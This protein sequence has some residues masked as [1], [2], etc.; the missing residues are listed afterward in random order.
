MCDILV[1]IQI[2]SSEIMKLMMEGYITMILHFLI[3]LLHGN[4]VW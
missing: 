1:C 2:R 4:I 3:R